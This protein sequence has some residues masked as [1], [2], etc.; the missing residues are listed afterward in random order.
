MEVGSCWMLMGDV[1]IGM[2]LVMGGELVFFDLLLGGFNMLMVEGD[3]YSEVVFFIFRGVFGGDDFVMD[4]LYVC[5]DSSGDVMVV[6]QNIGGFGVQM[7]EGIM[8]IQV[9]GVLVVNYVLVGCVVVGLYDYFLYKGGIVGGEGNWYLCLQLLI[10]LDLCE[11]DLL[12]LGCVLVDL[13]DFVDLVDLINL[14]LFLLVLC[15][16]V[17]VYLVNQLVVI[18]MFFYCL[19]DCIG[20]VLLDEGCVVWVCVGWQQVDFSV[21][22]G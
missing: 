18:N 11:V 13:I 22:G 19:N 7:L 17:G 21:V 12:Q 8:L 9:D 15:L 2:L 4:C 10:V 16:E 5:G 3:L 6:V 20:V 1:Y 14:I